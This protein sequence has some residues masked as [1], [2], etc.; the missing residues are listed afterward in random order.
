MSQTSVVIE[1][2][3]A[4]RQPHGNMYRAYSSAIGWCR[5]SALGVEVAASNAVLASLI[6]RAKQCQE[7][8][9]RKLA[10]KPQ[11]SADIG[12]KR[13]W[14]DNCMPVGSC[15]V[16]NVVDFGR[17]RRSLRQLYRGS[18]LH[19]SPCRNQWQAR[20]SFRGPSERGLGHKPILGG[21]LVTK[22]KASR[23]QILAVK[24]LEGSVREAGSAVA[25]P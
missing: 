20:E 22:G 15:R 4:K 3:R 23:K 18:V 13:R 19:S 8:E 25:I 2:G 24:H 14:W 6:S 5:G 10:F 21:N 17:I 1:E 16:P 12:K 9:G 11:S 7:P